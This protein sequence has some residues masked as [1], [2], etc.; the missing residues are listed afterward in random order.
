[1]LFFLFRPAKRKTWREDAKTLFQIKSLSNEKDFLCISLGSAHLLAVFFFHVH[2]VG[3]VE[4][5]V[6]PLLIAGDSTFNGDAARS[7]TQHKLF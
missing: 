5:A 3:R 1:M 4:A 6:H 2:E 7:R